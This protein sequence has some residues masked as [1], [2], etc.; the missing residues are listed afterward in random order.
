MGGVDGALSP[1]CL[2]MFQGYDL[3]ALRSR[4]FKNS[5]QPSNPSIPVIAIPSRFERSHLNTCSQL[6]PCFSS[7]KD[8]YMLS[9]L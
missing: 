1:G 3:G 9:S 2:P 8:N 7:I 5:N 4:S 6:I